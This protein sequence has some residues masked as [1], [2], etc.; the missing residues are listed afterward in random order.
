MIVTWPTKCTV[1]LWE[2]QFNK[3]HKIRLDEISN[4][5]FVGKRSGIYL[6]F[7]IQTPHNTKRTTPLVWFFLGGVR[8]I[9]TLARFL[10]AYSL[11]RGAPSASWVSLRIKDIFDCQSILAYPVWFVKS[12]KCIYCD[13]NLSSRPHIKFSVWALSK[14]PPFVHVPQTDEHPSKIP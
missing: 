2:M 7:I 1:H 14:T 5:I 13:E 12:K 11:S 8:G 4:R 3:K 9:W 6:Q 10:D